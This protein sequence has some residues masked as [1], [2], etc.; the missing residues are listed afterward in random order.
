MVEKLYAIQVG[1]FSDSCWPHYQIVIK[2]VKP[3]H[4]YRGDI[5]RV[6]MLQVIKLS[7]KYGFVCNML[8][9]LKFVSDFLPVSEDTVVEALSAN[10]EFKYILELADIYYDE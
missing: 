6:C 2:E 8:S 9:V 5:S 3:E 10:G 1:D 7:F 4:Y